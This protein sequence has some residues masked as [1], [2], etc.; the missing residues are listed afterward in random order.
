MQYPVY[1]VDAFANN[2]F[3]GN[4][5]AVCPLQTWLPDATMQSIA[6]ENNL[7]ETVFFVPSEKGFHIR[8]FTPTV[9]VVLC[10]H[11][12][13]ATAHILYTELGYTLPSIQ[14]ESKS[15]ELVVKKHPQGYQLNF[16]STTIEVMKGNDSALLHGL[17]IQKY[18]AAFTSVMDWMVVLENQDAIDALN[19]NFDI[20][21]TIPSRGIIV[22]A[23][24]KDVDFV[25]RCFYPQS[26]VKEDPVTGSSF[27]HTAPYWSERLGK[28]ALI[29]EQRSHRPGKVWLEIQDDRT[30]LA[31]PAITF[32]KGH[33]SLP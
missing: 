17:G 23:P 21:A 13:L 9:E 10:G 15:G 5:A 2:V 22:T 33:F 14:F 18:Q 31:G 19:P 30:L 26:G 16:P 6:A 20:L 4:P 12:T 11:A 7:S 27:T 28:T 8:W 1:I 3:E 29:G 32:S 25:C 24:G